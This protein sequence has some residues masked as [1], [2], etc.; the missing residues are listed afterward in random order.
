[1]TSLLSLRVTKGWV[2][3]ALAREV[4]SSRSRYVVRA[5][6]RNQNDLPGRQADGSGDVLYEAHSPH[7]K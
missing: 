6:L 5:T 2:A 4:A 3:S 1:M 7:I